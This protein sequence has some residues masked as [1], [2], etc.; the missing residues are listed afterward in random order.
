LSASG[1]VPPGPN[2]ARICG[3]CGPLTRSRAMGYQS[4]S[5]CESNST[6]FR[7]IRRR[8]GADSGSESQQKLT[9]LLSISSSRGFGHWAG[10]L[11]PGGGVSPPPTPQALPSER[12][13]ERFQGLVTLLV[14]F[15]EIVRSESLRVQP[16]LRL[17]FRPNSSSFLALWPS[18]RSIKPYIYHSRQ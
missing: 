5:H 2:I 7:A 11:C 18:T 10:P 17:C 15:R 12:R 6:G 9:S 1:T 3:Q 13:E 14:A 8:A 16:C 4:T